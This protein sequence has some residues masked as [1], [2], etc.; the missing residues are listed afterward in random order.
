MSVI[1]YR[2]YEITRNWVTKS[3][4][5]QPDEFT[6]HHTEYD[7]PED[8]RCGFGQTEADC[9][10]QIDEMEDE[11]EEPV[12]IDTIGTD[13]RASCCFTAFDFLYY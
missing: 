7:G 12:R 3:G 8:G 9:I 4:R 13:V 6:F 11:P 10:E 5:P 2:G 1:K